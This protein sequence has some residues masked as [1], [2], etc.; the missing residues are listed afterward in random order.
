MSQVT[1]LPVTYSNAS[2]IRHHGAGQLRRASEE[3][4]RC[5]HGTATFRSCT[6]A[7]GA[8]YRVCI[9]SPAVSA[10]VSARSASTSRISSSTRTSR[11]RKRSSSARS[12]RYRAL[13]RMRQS[14]SSCGCRA[15]RGQSARYAR[16]RTPAERY[17]YLNKRSE[18]SH[19]PTRC[20]ENGRCNGSSRLPRA[21][22]S[23][24]LRLPSTDIPSATS[25]DDGAG[26]TRW[27]GPKPSGVGRGNL[28]PGGSMT[29]PR[30]FAQSRPDRGQLNYCNNGPGPC[31]RN[32][33]RRAETRCRLRRRGSERAS[34]LDVNPRNGRQA[35]NTLAG[36]NPVRHASCRW[37]SS[38]QTK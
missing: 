22:L 29:A 36:S 31:A 10:S 9:T 5:A 38:G 7:T 15:P 30:A 19:Q 6:P 13:R 12:C 34:F 24:S 23:V 8:R 35:A 25:S 3:G 33:H 21:A 17:R 26:P 37:Q 14:A 32:P 27:H 11:R 20:A 16:C 28:R 4:H 2:C 1:F 18:N